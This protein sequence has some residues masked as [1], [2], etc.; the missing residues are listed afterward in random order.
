MIL[1]NWTFLIYEYIL[2]NLQGKKD[3]LFQKSKK[4]YD[5]ENPQ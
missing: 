5:S 1:F 2:I 3:H 4:N